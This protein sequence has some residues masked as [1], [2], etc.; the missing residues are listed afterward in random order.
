MFVGDKTRWW[1]RNVPIRAIGL[2]AGV[3][4]VA[5]C[6]FLY[7]EPALNTCV[8][9]LTHHSTATYQKISFKVPWMWRQ[10]EVPVGQREVRLSRSRWS[11][12]VT[13]ESIVINENTPTLLGGQSIG[14]RL[15]TLAHRLGHGRSTAEPFPLDAELSSKYLCVAPNL[16]G[17]EN[18]RLWCSS[19]DGL[20]LV[21]LHGPSA[22]VGDFLT[23]LRNLSGAR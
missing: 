1:N 10:E 3:V 14:Q 13:L 20:W 15:D 2:A 19:K 9:S 22:D 18:W 23:V 11:E 21:A 4:F 8:W 17:L 5:I 16:D 12:P 7:L 6:G